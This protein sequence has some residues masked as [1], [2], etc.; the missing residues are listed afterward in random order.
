MVDWSLAR[1]VA[2]LAAGS[3]GAPVD[4][5]LDLVALSAEMEGP[6]ASY[7]ALEPARPVPA[8]E[9]VGRADWVGLNL[10]SLSGLLD[11]VAATGPPS[12]SPGASTSPGR[13]PARSASAR[14]PRWLR[15][16][17]WSWATRR[18]ASLA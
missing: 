5:G 10:D 6:V 18:R 12:A 13:S 4:L 8:A 17:A 1:Q 16:R 9:V 7:T 2:R 3:E 14:A 15:R 11:P